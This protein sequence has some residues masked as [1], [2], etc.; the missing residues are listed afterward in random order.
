MG[1]QKDGLTMLQD[2]RTIQ[3]VFQLDKNITMATADINA[4]AYVLAEEA[5]QEC[6]DYRLDYDDDPPVNYI[7]N[8]IAAVQSK[9]TQTAGVRPMGV[10]C[11]IG[12]FDTD[13]KPRLFLTEPS[14]RCTEWMA[15]AIGGNAKQILEFLEKNYDESTPTIQT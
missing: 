11:L 14:G 3:K 10:A 1:I 12:G 7:A 9:Y 13:K 4:D 2:Q 6:Q 8:Y 15:K 5:R